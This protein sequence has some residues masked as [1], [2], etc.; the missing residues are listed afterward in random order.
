[1][2]KSWFQ[3]NT[4][5]PRLYASVCF[6]ISLC[7]NIFSVLFI[8]FFYIP[9]IITSEEQVI[10]NSLA[11][12]YYVI[13]PVSFIIPIVLSVFYLMPFI[14]PS[15]FHG[16][17]K[18]KSRLL[19]S[20]LLLALIGCTGWIFSLLITFALYLSTTYR[21]L[22][23]KQMAGGMLTMI[24]TFILV[25]YLLDLCNRRIFIP[26]LFGTSTLSTVDGVIPFSIGSK[27]IIFFITV[28]LFP[29]FVLFSYTVR[30]MQVSTDYSNM[31][32]LLG[33]VS[34]LL[35]TTGIITYL[36]MRT[37]KNPVADLEAATTKIRRGD[38][39]VEVQVR[40]T[41][42]LGRLTE[43]INETAV[44][45]HE[46]ELMK[47]T[48][49][50]LVDPQIRDYLLRGNLKL[51]GER[52]DSSILFSDIREFTTLSEKMA[53]ERTVDFLNHYFDEMNE[54]IEN[55]S[56]LVNKYIGDAVLGI[57]GNPLPLENHA[58]CAVNAAV[59][60]RERLKFLNKN[61]QDTGLPTVEFGVGIHSGEV[62]A[63]NI[64]SHSRMEYTVIGDTV[65]IA[66][67]LES[68][69][70]TYG[71][72]VI[73]SHATGNLLKHDQSIALREI[74]FVK[75]KGRLQPV[76]IYDLF[77][78]DSAKRKKSKLNSLD[79]FNEAVRRYRNRDF[80]L[81]KSMFEEC[82][83]YMPFDKVSRMYIKRCNTLLTHPPSENWSGVATIKV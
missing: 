35:L 29:V 71:V 75:V 10:Y 39:T 82:F 1:M 53:P 58:A 14:C 31:P 49:G 67:R 20:P 55:N 43:V 41:D 11:Q 61:L 5:A 9:S 64:G 8:N 78:G 13:V 38:F 45:L 50:K 33:I 57:F 48:F 32:R 40:S 21:I 62:I 81:A 36:F 42:Q 28:V 47:D 2:K 63:G 83:H 72:P 52:R 6:S 80:A 66:A 18:W 37:F 34:F 69:T 25:Y 59:T 7:A 44:S 54:C 4:F 19:N 23:L 27:F 30:S 17:D 15:R 16:R 68:L 65:N 60:M 46:K 77:E 79:T 51:G 24:F 22:L 74:D 3:N 73:I 76:R 56:G 12:D 70:K 26:R